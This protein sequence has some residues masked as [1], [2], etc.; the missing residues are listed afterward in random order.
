MKRL[1]LAS[2]TD[3]ERYD[4]DGGYYVDIDYDEDEESYK[5]TLYDRNHRVVNG[6]RCNKPEN[7]IRNCKAILRGDESK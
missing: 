2:F 4:F 5:W 6:G 3:K 1:I 7:A